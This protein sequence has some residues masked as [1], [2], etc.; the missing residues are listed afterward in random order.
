MALI[1]GFHKF[2]SEYTQIPNIYLRDTRLSLAAIGLYAQ[3]MSHRPGWRISQESL[4]RANG[5]GRD[6]MRTL[7]RELIEAGYLHRSEQRE[8]NASG[9]L[10]GYTYTTKEPESVEP[11]LD[12]PTQAE[13]THKNKIDKKNIIKNRER[14]AFD[15]FWKNYPKKQDKGLAERSFRKAL[16]FA[17]AEDII[18]GAARYASD[19]NLPEPRYIKNPST[20]LNAKAW[21]NG[22][23][24]ERGS[25]KYDNQDIVERWKNELS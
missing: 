5:I 20:W 21:E 4:A 12:E 6:A 19:P 13:P 14:E 24:P 25:R 15:E 16:S 18:E 1:R 23:L 7:L 9:Q 3:I 8:R 22:P 2:E 11:T 10:A 17:S